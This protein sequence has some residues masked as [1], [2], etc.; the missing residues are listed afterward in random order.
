MERS[1]SRQL[2]KDRI[3]LSEESVRK[4]VLENFTLQA[5]SGL[6][7]NGKLS[8][9]SNPI[10]VLNN[11]AS[12]N[13]QVRRTL[14]DTIFHFSLGEKGIPPEDERYIKA[15]NFLIDGTY[16]TITRV[17]NTSKPLNI[18]ELSIIENCKK[19]EI[20]KGNIDVRILV[21]DWLFFHFFPEKT[22][23]NEGEKTDITESLPVVHFKIDYE[24]IAR[25]KIFEAKI[26]GRKI[27]LKVKAARFGITGPT[28]KLYAGDE[29][30]LDENGKA[31]PKKPQGEINSQS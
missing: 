7:I 29:F 9:P 30:I 6:V 13:R 12:Y 5:L 16:D 15:A 3:D 23:K 18:T 11:L 14:S 24:K 26:K 10:A 17:F 25:V 19:L 27:P 28:Y 21:R 2:G 4:S 22:I 20:P 1:L 31:R 8:I